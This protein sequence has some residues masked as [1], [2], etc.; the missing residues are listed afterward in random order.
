MSALAHYLEDQG[1]ATTVVSLVRLHSEKVGPPRSLWVPYELGRPLGEPGDKAFQHRVLTAALNLLVDQP[2]HGAILDY[3]EEAPGHQPDPGWTPPDG[4]PSKLAAGA[5]SA[6]FRA[7]VEEEIRLLR[8]KHIAVVS[9]ASRTTMGVSRLDL[10]QILDLLFAIHDGGMPES[11]MEGVSTAQLMRYAV[12]DLKAFYLEAAGNNRGN[13]SS[14]QV[15]TWFWETTNAA[16]FLYALVELA[17]VSEDKRFKL[18]G[19][20]MLIPGAWRRG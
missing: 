19:S 14:K 5:S 1:L 20:N 8:P 6:D 11:S 18:I 3:A 13:P 15:T 16:E 9:R 7:K 12:D 10:E 2:E 4:L 17:K